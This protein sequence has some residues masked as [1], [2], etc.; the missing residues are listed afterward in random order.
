MKKTLFVIVSFIVVIALVD[1]LVFE[2]WLPQRFTKFLEK[3]V[4]NGSISFED[5]EID[6]F[7]GRL[8]GGECETSQ[9]KFTLADGSFSYSSFDWFLG[10]DFEVKHLELRGL[11]INAPNDLD[12]SVLFLPFLNKLRLNP[13]NLGCDT[14][15]VS[16]KFEMGVKAIPFSFFGSQTKSKSEIKTA[17]EF[18]WDD[19]LSFLGGGTLG[20]SP[21]SLKAFI[22]KKFKDNRKIL[23][24]SVLADQFFRLEF[25]NDGELESILFN[26]DSSKQNVSSARI[27][28]H[29]KRSEPKFHGD[30]N[31]T[32]L[33][34]DLAKYLPVISLVNT[35]INGGGEISFDVQ[36]K[37]IDIDVI[38]GIKAS[39]IFFPREGIL[40]GDV[41]SRIK[42]RE[43][44]WSTEGFDI[45]IK[46]KKGERIELQQDQSTGNSE[47]SLNFNLILTDFELGRFGQHFSTDA[48]INGI[49]STRILNNTLLLDSDDLNF[50]DQKIEQ[51]NISMSLEIPLNI[52]AVTKKNIKFNCKIL[53]GVEILL[54]LIPRVI[55]K[56]MQISFQNL[57]AVGYIE[58]DG[59][60]IDDGSL[61]IV[62]SRGRVGHIQ[63]KNTLINHVEGKGFMWS[64]VNTST[65][66]E[67]KFNIDTSKTNFSLGIK[68]F[69]LLGS[70]KEFDGEIVFV[71]GYPILHCNNFTFNG[72]LEDKNSSIFNNV[73]VKGDLKYDPMIKDYDQFNI[74]K[75]EFFGG[76]QMLFDGELLVSLGQDSE[77]IQLKSTNLDAN[78]SLKKI[79]LFSETFNIDNPQI[80]VN[81]FELE[82]RDG[83]EL[84][85]DGLLKLFS[86]DSPD[87]SQIPVN[88]TF[89]DK[90][91]ELSHWMRISYIKDMKSD[92]EINFQSKSNLI[93][94]RG[95]I[96][97]LVDFRSLYKTISHDR[98]N[99]EALSLSNFI[100]HFKHDISLSLKTLNIT[101]LIKLKD[102]DAD[103]NH[104]S[105]T[106]SF[107]STLRD[108][109]VHGEL[110]FCKTDENSSN[111]E[112]FKM[113]IK[114]DDTNATILNIL[115]SSN[116]LT[117]GLI[118]WNLEVKGVLDGGYK[119][120]FVG[121]FTKLSFNFLGK[122]KEDH[123]TILKSK[124]ESSLGNSF[125]W[126]VPQTKMIEVLS[127]L[128]EK[129]YFSKGSFEWNKSE[130]GAWKIFFKDWKSPELNLMGSAEYAPKGKFKMNLFPSVKGKWSNFLQAANLLAAGKNRDGYRT[131]KKEPL[132]L[133][134]S[135]ERLN[136]ASW[137]NVF[138][139]GLGL[140]PSE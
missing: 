124:M 11:T 7:E 39:S 41:R 48:S 106:V 65:P 102:F 90:N 95:K 127:L 72:R 21:L 2:W 130:S 104:L 101:P 92:L 16:G 137:W 12:S 89:V 85:F 86:V 40:S 36:G 6:W 121:D 88:W 108:S 44:N 115:D 136:L 4:A 138:A 18:R 87:F 52:N 117:D 109:A 37:E 114:G 55:K 81:K 125:S 78:L 25:T 105:K 79:P 107:T 43:K 46:N 70:V 58:R 61:E 24:I 10:N 9:W 53:S 98:N 30:W 67:T 135:N 62:N 64:Q 42:L 132:V 120:K 96:L 22:S 82:L 59:W 112:M 57:S 19:S 31:G 71:D 126:S 122:K 17:I 28:V 73:L 20:N 118:D 68:N 94:C 34:A 47:K 33:S 38:A 51:K 110:N 97:N 13:L 75:L 8:I 80:E 133:E 60:S 29:R 45:L 84:K 27:L 15:E 140:E 134:G 56:S 63:M 111:F 93:S 32:I 99:S 1:L 91:E 5:I 76:D 100:N 49:F 77:I 74:E 119:T 54:P 3:Q 113:E 14:V 123:V 83:T 66:Q 128:L 26:T 131:L 129:I 69:D 139:Q 116:V 35:E 23:K 103:F 50:S